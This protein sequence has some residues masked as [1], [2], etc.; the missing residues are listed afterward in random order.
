[1]NIISWVRNTHFLKTF[2]VITVKV[3]FDY[4]FLNDY[5]IAEVKI[6]DDDIKIILIKNLIKKEPLQ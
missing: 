3:P 1:M 5:I 4:K 2:N 6:K